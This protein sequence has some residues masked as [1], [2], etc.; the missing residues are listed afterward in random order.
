VHPHR[1]DQTTTATL[2]DAPTIKPKFL[3]NAHD[4]GL[5]AVGFSGGQVRPPHITQPLDSA[6][7]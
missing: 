2:M 1:L 5:V 6:D 4:L 3:P 7:A